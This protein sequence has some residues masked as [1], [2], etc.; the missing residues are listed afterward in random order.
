[1]ISQGSSKLFNLICFCTAYILIIY[2]YIKFRVSEKVWFSNNLCFRSIY[3]CP[4]SK[5]M[6]R[7][8]I[9]DSFYVLVQSSNHFYSTER[10]EFKLQQVRLYFTIRLNLS[11]LKVSEMS[12]QPQEEGGKNQ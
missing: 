2:Y 3:Y 9:Y 11:T 4:H 12:T 10:K 8:D 7:G 1:M 5:V 6:N